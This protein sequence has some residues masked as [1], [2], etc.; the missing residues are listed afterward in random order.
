MRKHIKI[1]LALFL[2]LTGFTYS[3]IFSIQYWYQ[4]T[5][6]DLN[7]RQLT[8]LKFLDSL[9]GFACTDGSSTNTGYILKTTNGGD[10]WSIVH[11]Y[12]TKFEK[13]QFINSQTGYICAFNDNLFKTTNRGDNWFTIPLP[14][15]FPQD[16]TALNND[17]IWLTTDSD[18][19]GGVF[20]TTNGGANWT[21]KY[22]IFGGNP[23]K[24]YMI[25]MNTGFVARNS[26]SGVPLI[27]TT[28]GGN[29]WTS[30]SGIG[31]FSDMY[32][33]D[34]LNG[35]KAPFAT[36]FEK[37]TNGGVNWSQ[38]NLLNGGN[39][40]ETGITKFKAINRDTIFGV[41]GVYEK[42]SNLYGMIWRTTNGGVNWGF[43]LT[44]TSI[45]ISQYRQIDFYGKNYGW[46]YH[47]LGAGIHTKV[48]GDTTI[49]LTG[50]N[51][52]LNATA[53]CFRLFQNYPNPFNP[54]TTISY[55]L[56]KANFV[57]LKIYN[58]QGKETTVLVSGKKS[59]GFYEV[60]FDA[61][62]YNLSSGIYFYSLQTENYTETKKMILVK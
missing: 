34:T 53:S 44:D 9:T 27:K 26:N 61:N 24:I 2:L 46:C 25:N 16:M 55:Y 39:V 17:T 22:N 30:Y 40:I 12:N 23:S 52:Y 20:V 29:N 5:M 49:F 60:S 33:F 47:R 43:Q 10:N 57:S 38:Y 41:Y 8:D 42:N 54:Q 6:A 36:Y 13:I 21:N 45:H 1:I 48:G 56:P 15:T 19:G 37:T 7:G 3:Y 50:V 58:L 51:N 59:E 4:Q 35:V 28:N 14:G 62:K 18:I 32:F 11:S 31:G